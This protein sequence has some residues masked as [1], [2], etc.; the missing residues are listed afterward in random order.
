[1]NVLSKGELMSQKN[2]NQAKRLIE[3]GFPCHQVGAETQRER[4]T[5]KAPPVNRLHVWWARRPLTASRAAV[6][7]SLLPSDTDPERFLRKL[8]IEKVQALVNGDPWTLTGS[9]LEKVETQNWKQDPSAQSPAPRAQSPKPR[10]QSPAPSTQSPEPRAQSPT[11]NAQRPAPRAQSPAPRVPSPEP[12]VQSPEPKAQRPAPKAQRPKPRITVDRFVLRALEREEKQRAEN[13]KLI[14]SL[15]NKEPGLAENRVIQHWKAESRPLPPPWPEIGQI[16][17]VKKVMGD[18][19]QAK[20]KMALAKKHGIH[21]P[22]NIYGYDRAFEKP[23]HPSSLSSLTLLDPTSGG[24]SIPFEALRLGCHVIANDLNPVAAGILHATLDYPARFGEELTEDIRAWGERLLDTL[25]TKL[26]AFFPDAGPLP[27]DERKNLEEHLSQSPEILSPFDE[28]NVTGYLFARQV[29][30]PHCGGEVPLLNSSSVSRKPGNSWGIRMHTDGRPRGGQIH[31]ETCRVHNGR[32]P[33]GEDPNF[34]TVNRGVGFCLHCKQA[35]SG[36]DIKA[37]AKG[38]SPLGKWTDRLYCVVAIRYEPDNSP[39]PTRK[40]GKGRGKGR[41]KKHRFFRPPNESDLKALADA[42]EFLRDRWETWDAK[43]LIPTEKIPPG[44]K[45]SEPLRYGITR[46]IDMFTPRQLLGHLTLVEELNRHIP[47]ILE[48]LGPEKGK[49]VVTYLQ[50]AVDKGLDYNSRHTRWIPQRT[51]VSGT[52][53]RH[54]FSLKWTFGEMIFIGPSSGAAWGLSQVIDAYK[55]IA[56]LL[57]PRSMQIREGTAPQLRIYNDTAAHLPQVPD[58]SVDRV[59]MDPPYYDNVQYA[60]LSDYFYVW[61]KRTLKAIYPE[62][63]SRRLTNKKEEAVANPARDGSAKEAKET[64]QR[65]MQ[66]IFAECFRVLRPDGLLTLMFTHKRQD[67]WETLTRSLIESGWIITATVPVESEFAASL[68]QKHKAAAASAIFIACRKRENREAFPAV[69]RGMA[70]SGV[71]HQIQSAVEE[72]LREF[73]HL[74]L[75]P[76]DQMVACYGRALRVLSEQWPVMDGDDSVTPT[77]AMDE[78]SRVVS[79]YQIKR[80]TGNRLTVDD[81]DPETAM[82]LTLFGIWRL[83]EFSFDETLNISKSLNISLVSRN[84]GYRIE[85]RMIGMNRQAPT[86]RDGGV[87]AETSGFHAPLIRKG[88]R[89]RLARPEERNPAR[90]SDPRSHWDI[91]QGLIQEYRKGDIPL[92]RPYLKIHAPNTKEIILDILRVW[93]RESEEPDLKKE[94][95]S[96]LFGLK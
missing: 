18:P 22:G 32:G 5:G 33:D 60:E 78:A 94:A 41:G 65:M 23:L 19:A 10:A 4:D 82:A 3:Q 28:E 86:G 20:E 77:R 80:I 24:G 66:D 48:S 49:A 26:S 14:E 42:E 21:F 12:R 39:G 87:K 44:Q 88:S 81:L 7:S 51:S 92:A 69:W 8:G 91:L 50:Y 85:G 6:L 43:D 58:G 40:P 67:A 34:G 2:S 70:G 64:Y 61:Q 96:I 11:P 45:T 15:I 74:R 46:W 73:E 35:V 72:G 29:V 27:P 95:E 68:H 62:I 1:M 76:V 53:G 17:P 93:A 56:L 55:G 38:E 47:Q 57:H 84:S 83:G 36:D 31:F 9:L 16:L 30:C 79:A 90:L 25:D 52:F 13:R 37:Q 63:F 54:D 71:Q 75:N 59:C 89:L